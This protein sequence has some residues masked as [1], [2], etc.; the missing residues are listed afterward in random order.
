MTR[1]AEDTDTCGVASPLTRN[2]LRLVTDHLAEYPVTA[3]LIVDKHP[4]L[5]QACIL[6]GMTNEDINQAGYIGVMRAAQKYDPGINAK[7]ATYAVWWIRSA[8]QSELNRSRDRYAD[9]RIPHDG[10][11][12][13]DHKQSKVKQSAEEHQHNRILV[14]NYLKIL[15]QRSASILRMYYGVNSDGPIPDS[16][17]ARQLGI[18]D[19]RVNQLRLVA[20]QKIR[21]HI[22]S[23]DSK[24]E[25]VYA[26]G[27]IMNDVS[28]VSK[29]RICNGVCDEDYHHDARTQRRVRR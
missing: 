6:N 23:H 8:V 24:Q 20:L 29:R 10:R 27:W 16:A 28:D 15:D 5:Y 21:E 12:L 2:Q 25:N 14:E 26:R 17:I 3:A 19:T 9:V 13:E 18:S 7:F 1:L 4:E 11:F 22:K